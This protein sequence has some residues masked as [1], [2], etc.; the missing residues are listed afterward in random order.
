MAVRRIVSNIHTDD[1]TALAAF[2]S[3]VFDLDIVMDMGWIATL[4][5]QGIYVDV[6][7]FSCACIGAVGLRQGGGFVLALASGFAT[8]DPV[9]GAIQPIGQISLPPECRLNDGRVDH[10]GRFWAGAM[11][12]VDR[13]D[14]PL[15]RLDP[16]HAIH[17]MREG[18]GC[19]NSS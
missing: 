18:I 12:E 4:A 3:D 7:L 8:F 10:Q 5:A 16:D 15:F 14:A 1:P 2:Y 17:L 9:T 11:S 13:F 19:S 6:L